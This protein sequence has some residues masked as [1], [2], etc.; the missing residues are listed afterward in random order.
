MRPAV[1]LLWP[2]VIILCYCTARKMCEFLVSQVS[3]FLLLLLVSY[4]NFWRKS[5]AQRS[6]EK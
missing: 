6:P 1:K 3:A 5:R 2:H 4:V